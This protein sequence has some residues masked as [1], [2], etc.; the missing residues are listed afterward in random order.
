M[1]KKLLAVLA[2]LVVIFAFFDAN[3]QLLKDLG[4]TNVQANWIK[5]IGLILTSLLPSINNLFKK[6]NTASKDGDDKDGGG[7]VVPTKGF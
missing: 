3:F 2:V 7:A 4:I 1:S 6:D 5:L